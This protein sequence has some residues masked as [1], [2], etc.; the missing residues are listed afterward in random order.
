M[1]HKLFM[2]TLLD[3]NAMIEYDYT[4]CIANRR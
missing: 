3:N 2:R 1:T 4:V